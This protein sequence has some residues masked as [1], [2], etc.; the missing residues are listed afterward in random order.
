MK[1]DKKT[2]VLT[3]NFPRTP[4]DISAP[5]F[6]PLYREINKHLPLLFLVPHDKGLPLHEIHDGM[7]INRFRYGGD[8][9]ETLAYRGDMH[10]QVFRRPMRTVRFF[11][12]F[13]RGAERLIVENTP[14][15]VWAQWWIPGGWIATRVVKDRNL[16]LVISCHGTDIFLLR[17]FPPL[18]IPAAKV[19]GT[20]SRITVVSE[21]LKNQLLDYLGSRVS[22]L[23]QKLVVAP[24]P[25]NTA[26][27]SYD[28]NVERIPG[29]VV[30]A[31]RYTTQK[32]T[33][34]LIRA[35]AKLRSENIP[36]QVDLYGRGPE[37]QALQRMIDSSGLRD[38]FRLND[39][40]T[41]EE[42]ADKYRTAAISLLVSEREGFGLTL[43][44]AMLCGCAVIGTRS[45]GITDI[46][47]TDGEDGLLVPLDDPDALYQALKQLLTDDTFRDRLSETGRLSAER[48]FSSEAIVGRYMKL[49]E[50]PR[51]T[52]DEG[53]L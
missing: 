17:R 10:K 12:S 21:Y 52:D 51:Y 43:V 1:Q 37:R 42:L 3:H 25:V 14:N 8:E 32:K 16:P 49:L 23:A 5:G 45:G 47:K 38:C 6:M 39:S 4:D 7:T 15:L 44:E 48:R 27:F 2:L 18:R 40:I 28:K 19:F 41:H 22:N 31:T 29:T 35:V 46:I 34:V 53:V 33:D 13:R 20:A 50:A 24:L 36:F 30:A 26:C 11:R 9:A